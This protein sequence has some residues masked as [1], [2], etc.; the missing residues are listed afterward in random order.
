MC[1]NP[2]VPSMSASPSDIA[3]IGSVTS[4]P[5]PSTPS[6]Y[7]AAASSNSASGLKPN[8]ESTSPASIDAPPRSMTALTIC[9]QVVAI[10]PPN[11]T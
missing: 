11:S 9:T 5:G 4:R 6:P 8:R 2:A 3:S 7:I 1:G 10:M